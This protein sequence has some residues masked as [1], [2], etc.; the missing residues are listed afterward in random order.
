MIVNFCYFDFGVVCVVL[1]SCMRVCVSVS[2]CACVLFSLFCFPY[3]VFA[4]VGLFISCVFLYVV[5]HLGLQF[6]CK[7]FL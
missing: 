5:Y 4:G 2:I 6:S 3:F 7:Y 1:C